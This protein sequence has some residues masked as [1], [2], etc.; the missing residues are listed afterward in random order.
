MDPR[1]SA[2]ATLLTAVVDYEE[3]TEP[4]RLGAVSGRTTACGAPS[5]LSLAVTLSTAVG[6]IA[7]GA[8]PNEEAQPSHPR[9]GFLLGSVTCPQASVVNRT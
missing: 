1:D 5:V 6:D 7:R 4:H 8:L 3:S 9:P 2:K